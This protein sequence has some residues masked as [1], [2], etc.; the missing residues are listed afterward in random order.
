MTDDGTL[1]PDSSSEKPQVKTVS[2]Q[3]ETLMDFLQCFYD[4]KIRSLNNKLAQRIARQ[5]SLPEEQISKLLSMAAESDPALDR[6]LSLWLGALPIQ[7]YPAV[8]DQQLRFAERLVRNASPVGRWLEGD[9]DTVSIRTMLADY[10]QQ[11]DVATK[12]PADQ[13]KVL[14]TRL[15]NG[16]LLASLIWSQRGVADSIL[17]QEWKPLLSAASDINGF[18][19]LVPLIQKMPFGKLAGVRSLLEQHER[20]S[21][22]MAANIQRLERLVDSQKLQIA[23]LQAE[24]SETQQHNAVLENNLHTSEAAL[25]QYKEQAR[26]KSIHHTDDVHQ[27]QSRINRLLQAELQLLRDALVA[28]QRDPPKVPV[29]L[30]YLDE[31]ITNIDKEATRLKER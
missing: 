18:A 3:I 23:Q 22:S 26:I 6:T 9:A 1:P 11:R 16:I 7:S 17:L 14:L 28:L 8:R 10:K 21:A 27:L 15:D 13:R 19:A 12:A 20:H 5:S 24:L 25:Q 2:S 30:D 31:A 29:A 4:G